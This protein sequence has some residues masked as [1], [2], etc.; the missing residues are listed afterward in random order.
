MGVTGVRAE[1]GGEATEREERLRE[2]AE[3]GT[4]LW[5]SWVKNG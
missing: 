1:A 4:C 3:E 2:R 5:E